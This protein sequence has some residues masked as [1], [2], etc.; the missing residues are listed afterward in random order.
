M[1]ATVII[2]IEPHEALFTWTAVTNRRAEYGT[3]KTPHEAFDAALVR[4]AEMK[5]DD[6][7]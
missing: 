2:D 5:K 4:L 3:C 6:A 1:T 7:S